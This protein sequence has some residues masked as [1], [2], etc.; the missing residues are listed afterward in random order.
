MSLLKNRK[1]RPLDAIDRHRLVLDRDVIYV[2]VTDF[3]RVQVSAKTW[4]RIERTKR[5][6]HGK[7]TAA[8]IRRTEK[9][10][11][12]LCRIGARLQWHRGLTF[13]RAP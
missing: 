10:L 5:A 13:H 2:A 9:T 6:R 8:S 1:R 11:N 3:G 12:R 4:E 7:Q